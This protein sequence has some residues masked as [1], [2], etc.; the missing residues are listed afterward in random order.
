MGTRLC[1][2]TSVSPNDTANGSR[3]TPFHDGTPGG[4]APARCSTGIGDVAVLS[5]DRFYARLLNT[6]PVSSVLAPDT[7]ASRP[8]FV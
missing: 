4:F 6:A 2:I 3:A 8:G 1:S 7:L 5:D